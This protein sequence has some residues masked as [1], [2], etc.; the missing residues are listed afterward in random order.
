MPS[1]SLLLSRIADSEGHVLGLSYVIKGQKE[2]HK[3][4]GFTLWLSARGH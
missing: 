2:W 1:P 4:V 3:L